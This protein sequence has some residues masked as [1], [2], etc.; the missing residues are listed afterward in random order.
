[1]RIRPYLVVTAFAPN[2]H[3]L[4]AQLS[5]LAK[6]LNRLV[7]HVPGKAVA[8]HL[9][10]GRV[11]EM[12]LEDGSRGG[13]RHQSGWGKGRGGKYP[14]ELLCYVL[15]DELQYVSQPGGF[16]GRRASQLSGAQQGRG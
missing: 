7:L 4:Q 6:L 10:R 2:I 1:M 9:E 11:K 15:V 5:Q 3:L 13:K 8:T 16:E 14:L 12:T